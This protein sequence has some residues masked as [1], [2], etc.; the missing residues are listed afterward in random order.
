MVVCIFMLPLL[1]L[2]KFST[3][4]ATI[5]TVTTTTTTTMMYAQ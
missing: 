5:T 2:Y 1:F 4:Y 3:A